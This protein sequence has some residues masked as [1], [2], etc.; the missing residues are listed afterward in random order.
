MK[1]SRKEIKIGKNKSAK[2]KIHRKMKES[3]K[4]IKKSKHKQAKDKVRKKR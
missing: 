1:D 2:D 4:K 3:G